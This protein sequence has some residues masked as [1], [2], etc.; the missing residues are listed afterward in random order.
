MQDR[1]PLVLV[2]HLARNLQEGTEHVVREL[3]GESP[4]RP[5]EPALEVGRRD[6]GEDFDQ[7]L[8]VLGRPWVRRREMRAKSSEGR[9]Y[10]G[11]RRGLKEEAVVISR[12]GRRA[13]ARSDPCAYHDKALV[14]L[15]V[16]ILF[17][18]SRDLGR[19]RVRALDGVP[20]RVVGRQVAGEVIENQRAD[21]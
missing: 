8:D 15:E 1:L 16:S 11:E 7:E 20:A 6:G 9:V 17:H 18:S 14:L 10:I 4:F 5:A 19:Q 3:I 13:W 12:W 21:W 2:L